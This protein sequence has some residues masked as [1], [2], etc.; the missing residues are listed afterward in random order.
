[1]NNLKSNILPMSY[2]DFE[3]LPTSAIALSSNDIEGAAEI[4]DRIPDELK[5]WQVYLNCLALSAFEQWLEER[6]ELVATNR[7]KCTILQ[8]ALANFINGV[9]NLQVGEFKVCLIATGSLSDEMVSLPRVVIDLPEFIPHFYVLVEVLEEQEAANVYAFLSYPELME[10]LD[11]TSLQSDWNYQLPISC[12]DDNPDRLLLYFRCLEVSAIS[13]PAIPTNRTGI[14]A[15]V[16]NQLLELL[17]ELRSPER[18]L[19][20]ILTWEQAT[21]VFTNPELLNWVY[22]L[23]KQHLE[24]QNQPSVNT[25]LQDLIKLITQPALNAG[26]WL[27]NELDELAQELSWVLLPIAS[28]SAMRSMRSPAEEF[29][30]IVTQ[31]RQRGLEIPIQARGAYQDLLLAGIPLRLYA[32]TWHLVAES[33]QPKWSLLLILGAPALSNLPSNIKLR[34]SDQTGI[35]EELGLNVE[36]KDSYIFTCV[37]GNWDEK[38]LVSVSLMDGVEVTLLPFAFDL[39]R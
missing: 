23:Q 35:L 15:T 3:T 19:S 24:T 30:V 22:T 12:F 32:V 31:L 21:A 8:P 25:S 28:A 34:V 7:D 26:R 29:E 1:M 39:G 9:A 33:E 27:W 2:L 38:F 5:Q 37:V 13:L 18:E 16:Q 14:L 36:S 17:P 20:N 10:T 11:V 4:S 6:T